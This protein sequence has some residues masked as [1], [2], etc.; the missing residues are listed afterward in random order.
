MKD[1]DQNPNIEHPGR[2]PLG[3]VDPRPARQDKFPREER[4]DRANDRGAKKSTHVNDADVGE[5]RR[6]GEQS[7]PHDPQ[8]NPRTG[9]IG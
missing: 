2:G 3:D 5:D 9:P 8:R 4:R 6:G 1:K 7:G